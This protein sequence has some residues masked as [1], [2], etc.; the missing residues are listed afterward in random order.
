MYDVRYSEMSEA[1]G[2]PETRNW[3]GLNHEEHEEREGTK[4]E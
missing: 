1:N 2:Q 3:G 4:G